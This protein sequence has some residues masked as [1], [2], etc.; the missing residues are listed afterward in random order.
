MNNINL[1]SKTIIISLG[2]LSLS[3]SMEASDFFTVGKSWLRST[4]HTE[5]H[6]LFS[7]YNYY[8]K[9]SVVG[10]TEFNGKQ[11]AEIEVTYSNVNSNFDSD[12]NDKNYIYG[13]EE[14]GIIY[15]YRDSQNN[16]IPILD[17]N[18]KG[19]DYVNEFWDIQDVFYSFI[20]GN[21]RSILKLD[22]DNYWIEDIGCTGY[23]YKSTTALPVSERNYLL[24]CRIGDEIIYSKDAFEN[25]INGCPNAIIHVLDCDTGELLDRRDFDWLTLL[26]KPTLIKNSDKSFTF[27]LDVRYLLLRENPDTT[28]TYSAYIPDYDLTEINGITLP[29]A[30]VEM[31][32]L[33]KYE[34]VTTEITDIQQKEFPITLK[35]NSS[36]PNADNTEITDSTTDLL[37][38][39]IIGHDD[40]CESDADDR[41]CIYP[42]QYDLNNKIL[43]VTTGLTVEIEYHDTLGIDETETNPTTP[44]EYFTIQGEKIRLPQEKG[45]YIKREGNSYSK[46]LIT[47]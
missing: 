36:Y 19:G 5:D 14:N 16:Y 47:K 3:P 17:F 9:Y 46:I 45:V 20:Y 43:T 7:F 38:S 35:N 1:Y 27:S 23:V 26:P 42:V 24:E 31:W 21:E 41:F 2:I 33:P 6:S 13:Y 15:I 30:I 12:S 28:G 37:P 11:A 44:T 39:Q 29:Y 10:E 18:L 8:T 4:R 40:L 34:R 25:V 32:I 22:F